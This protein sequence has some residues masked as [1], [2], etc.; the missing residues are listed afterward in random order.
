VNTQLAV[1]RVPTVEVLDP[2]PA[3]ATPAEMREMIAQAIV[4][5]L[6]PPRLTEQEQERL[7]PEVFASFLAN[8]PR[9]GDPRPASTRNTY[10]A[11]WEDLLQFCPK[12]IWHIKASDVRDWIEDLRTRPIQPAVAK[13]LV[14]NGRRRQ[15]QVGLSGSTINVW[16]SAIS[17]FYSYCARFPVQTADGREIPLFNDMNPAKNHMVRRPESR[18]FEEVVYLDAEQLAALLQAIR[19][20]RTHNP[21]KSLRDYALFMA[22]IATGARNSEIRVWQWSDIRPRGTLV[23]YHWRNKGKEGLDQLPDDAWLPLENYL[24][25]TGRIRTIQPDDYIW[26]PLND[27][28]IR[29]KRPDGSPL[30]DPATWTRNRPLSSQ[31]IN[32]SLRWYARRAGLNTEKLH[33][34]CLR[35]SSYMLYRDAGVTLEERSRLLHHSSLAITTHYD[36]AVA[37]QLNTGW[38]KAAELLGL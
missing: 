2:E 21:I 29:F 34:H 37:G 4:D 22:Y 28:A 16:I 3:R 8:N 24:T 26:T 11:A 14:R 35:H 1:V 5:R 18:A 9:T 12:R 10:A 31:E 36:H 30:I 33:V 25:V 13:G 32:R 17:S 15:G 20:A 7:Y 38:R 6:N 23:F 19:T 27:A